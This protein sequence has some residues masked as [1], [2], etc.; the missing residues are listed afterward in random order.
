MKL[1]FDVTAPGNQLQGAQ[2]APHLNLAGQ[3]V[4]E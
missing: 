4:L 2:G 3:I 1:P